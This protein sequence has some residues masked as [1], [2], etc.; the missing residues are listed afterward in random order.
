MVTS[1]CVNANKK[2]S[3][4]PSVIICALAVVGLSS[5]VFAGPARVMRKHMPVEVLRDASGDPLRTIDSKLVSSNWSGYVL[6][7]FLT[8]HHYMIAQATW[9]VPTVTFHNIEAASSSWIGIGGFCTSKKC[10]QVDESLI[11]LGTEQDALSDTA[12]DYYAWYEM[13][14]DFAIPTSLGVSPG[15]VITASLSCAG[16]CL[17]TQVWTLSMTNETTSQS[18]TQDFDYPS[19]NLSLEV[20]EEAPTGGGGVLPLANFGKATFSNTTS[21]SMSVNFSKGDSIVLEDRQPHQ[22][23]ESSNVSAPA[24]TKDGFNACFNNSKTLAKCTKP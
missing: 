12:S 11:Q 21:S 1:W 4:L 17:S 22:R 13:L 14:P 2:L 16:D 15:D 9:T 10:N 6:P 3:M 23:V 24:P 7:K 18:W 19:A 5:P 8:K 20:I